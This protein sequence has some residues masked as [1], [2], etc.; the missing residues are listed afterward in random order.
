[1]SALEYAYKLG[2]DSELH[3]PNPFIF[4]SEEYSAYEIGQNDRLIGD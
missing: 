4:G 2:R 1:M 3:C